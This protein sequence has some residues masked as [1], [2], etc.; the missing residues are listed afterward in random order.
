MV[1]GVSPLAEALAD[2]AERAGRSPTPRTPAASVPSLI[3]DCGGSE[4][5]DPLQGGPQ[6]L[7]C[8]EAPLAALDP[9]GSAAGFHATVAARGLVELTRSPTTS[10]A[11]RAPPRRSSPRSAAT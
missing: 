6:L 4:A 5:E 7:L 11:A 1:A 9:E 10:N 2:A 8:A 3:V